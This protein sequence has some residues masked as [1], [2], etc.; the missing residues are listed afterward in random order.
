MAGHVLLRLGIALFAI[1]VPIGTVFS[2]RL[3]FVL[4]PVSAALIIVGGVLLPN[5]GDVVLRHLRKAMTR[6]IL[7]LGTLLLIWAALS[8]IWTPFPELASERFL[9]SVGT[10]L[11][12]TIAIACMPERLKAANGN[13]LPIGIGLAGIAALGAGLINPAAFRS[14]EGDSSLFQRAISG[15]LVMGWPAL[16]V[17]VTRERAN[18]AIALAAILVFATLLAAIPVTVLTLLISVAV[19]AAAR[20]APATT[21]T[22]VGLTGALLMIAAPALVLA[23]QPVLSSVDLLGIGTTFNHWA[24]IIRSEGAK[25]VTGHG[26]DTSLRAVAAGILPQQAPRGILFEVWYELGAVGAVGSA[27]LI[28]LT[29]LAALRLGNLAPYLLASLSAVLVLSIAGTSIAQLWWT[30]QLASGALAVALVM[31][32]QPARGRVRASVLRQRPTL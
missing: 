7:L 11:A 26:F 32:V 6:P 15:L 31:R 8:F 4:V 22:A 23:F 13:L 5:G 21:G 29:S 14:V 18:Y 24:E 17:L 30:T 27:V 10:I 9:K 16:A 3:L 19:F 12:A 1:A 28:W 20:Q 2:R 25:L